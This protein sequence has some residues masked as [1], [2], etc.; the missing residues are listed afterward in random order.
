MTKLID[1]SIDKAM[2]TEMNLQDKHFKILSQIRKISPTAKLLAVSKLQPDVKIREV[3]NFGQ[4]L[5]GENYVQEF[6]K[7]KNDLADLSID[8]HFIGQLQTNKV[9]QIAG[10]CGLIHSIDSIKLL[11]KLSS[12]LAAGEVKSPQKILLQ[13]NLSGEDSKA[14][15]TENEILNL[16][17]RL[18][19]LPQVEVSG[20]MTLPPLQ[21][22][23]SENRIYFKKLRLLFEKLN[24]SL[25]SDKRLIELSMGTS[26]DF[27]IALEEGASIVRVGTVLFGERT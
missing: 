19:N 9:K 17:D 6:L 10:G 23:A 18:W 15:F 8:W 1:K 4:R 7:K 22:E 2:D 27:H 25:P 12:A 5:F 20:L 14:G 24:Q 21:N 3:F 26:H 16:E 13:V 11:E